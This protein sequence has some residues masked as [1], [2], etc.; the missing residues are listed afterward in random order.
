MS[1]L[2]LHRNP[3]GP[4][5]FDA[6][7]ADVPGGVVLLAAGD[8][9]RAAGERPP[10][11]PGGYRHLEVLPDFEDGAR[12]VR[13]ALELAAEH[14]VRHVV[15]FHEGDLELAAAVREKLGLPGARPE[16]VLPFRDKVLMKERAAAAGVR[17]APHTV[18]GG[19]DDVARFV[20][21]HG[22]PV[23]LKDRDG[24]GSRGLRVLR[25][26]DDLARAVAEVFPGGGEPRDDML[27]EAWVPG[28][29][30]HV[31]GLVVDGVTVL[32]WPSQYQYELASFQ[33]DPG[34]R[35]DLTLE[36]DD[37]LTGRL[38]RMADDTLAALDGPRTHAFHLEAFHTPDDRLVLCE[39][40]ARPGGA[41]IREVLTALFG[42]NPARCAARAEVG[43]GDLGIEAAAGERPAPRCMAGQVLLM[44][45]PGRVTGVPSHPGDPWVEFFGV[46]A[47]AGQVLDGAAGSADFLA[48]AVLSGPTREECERRLRAL[49]ARFE[50]EAVIV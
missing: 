12:V 10:D 19:A 9:I 5:P 37:P 43:L 8:R 27:L 40:A 26:E 36:P 42:V 15:A 50:A 25:T 35:V 6:W 23:V 13:R 49:G 16:Q 48:A 21:G 34:A 3:L 39:V 17:V 46:F 7:L 1:V 38:L 18:P 31:D 44:K 47:E 22:L 4:F 24:F 32:A 30:C 14:G 45:R 29:M 11:G 41:R 28:R 20:A 33:A 2:V